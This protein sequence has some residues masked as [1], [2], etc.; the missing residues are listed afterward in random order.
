MKTVIII[1]A[2]Y[3][4]TR[5]PGKPTANI[6]GKSLLERTWTIAKSVSS[7]DLVVIAT[8]DERIAEHATKFGA[9][10]QLTDKR[11]RNGTERTL[12]TIQLLEL[13]PDVVVNL[14]GDAVLT[15]PT[16]IESLLTAL[17]TTRK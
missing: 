4:S 5:F 9:Q 7:A 1:P 11:W 17:E 2:R 13:S 12:E 16:A 10:V 15:P 8:D 3:A 6:L 14:Q